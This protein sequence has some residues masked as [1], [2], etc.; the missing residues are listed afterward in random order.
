M[1]KLK[2]ASAKHDGNGRC[3]VRTC[4]SW[5]GVS[6]VVDRVETRFKAMRR[7][8]LLVLCI[9]ASFSIVAVALCTT[10]NCSSATHVDTSINSALPLQTGGVSGYVRDQA[11]LAAL[12]GATIKLIRA[13]VGQAETTT[14][15]SGHYTFTNL[16]AGTY[17]LSVNASGYRNSSHDLDY[18]GSGVALDF[19]LSP[20]RTGTY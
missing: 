3:S 18:S 1:C 9:V 15:A 14:S 8:I 17:T 2:T 4:A 6:L 11:T 5:S 19:Y 7:R 12:G 13:G 10:F 20:I 16:V